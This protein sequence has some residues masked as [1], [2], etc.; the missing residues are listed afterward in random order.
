[1]AAD[2]D[3]VWCFLVK[4]QEAIMGEFYEKLRL[5]TGVNAAA[6]AVP[7]D[8]ALRAKDFN[9][10]QQWLLAL[11]VAEFARFPHIPQ[12][13]NENDRVEWV[14]RSTIFIDLI[15]RALSIDMDLDMIL[16]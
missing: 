14:T 3:A 1:M 12:Y 5:G 11:H 4:T 7:P 9:D 6:K 13:Q 2:R 16:I 15:Q 8:Q 10:L